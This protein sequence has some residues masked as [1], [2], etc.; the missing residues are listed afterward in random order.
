VRETLK[1]SAA[2][3]KKLKLGKRAIVLGTGVQVLAKQGAVVVP[4][5]LTARGRS[6]VRSHRSLPLTS[7]A[8]VSD[9]NGNTRTSTRVFILRRS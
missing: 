7:T 4:V 8:S 1:L 2:Q 5:R 3:A 6:L 9:P